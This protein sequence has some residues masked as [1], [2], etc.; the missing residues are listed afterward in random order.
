[1]ST[2]FERRN[3]ALEFAPER[4]QVR[5]DTLD[6]SLQITE[7]TLHAIESDIHSTKT[8]AHFV[9][10]S[11]DFVAQFG[12]QFSAKFRGLAAVC[13]H[14]EGYNVEQPQ[15]FGLDVVFHV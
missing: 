6:A 4:S 3:P 2:R 8:L 13:S 14:L 11:A 1:M 9:T 10:Q 5:F 12:A 15:N 7:S